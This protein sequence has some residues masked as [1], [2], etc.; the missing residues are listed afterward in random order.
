MRP[1]H[2]TSVPVPILESRTAAGRYRTAARG[3]EERN[4]RCP[5]GFTL[6]ELLVVMAVIA[7]LMAILLPALNLARQYA[8]ETVCQSNLRQMAMILKTYCDDHDGLFPDPTYIYHSRES[9]KSSR[10]RTPFTPDYGAQHP[11]TCRWHDAEI[12]PAGPLLRAHKELQGSLIPYVGNGKVLLCKTGA[13]ACRERGCCNQDP[14]RPRR[15][16]PPP[17]PGGGGRGGRWSAH[18]SLGTSDPN[19]PIPLIPQ[20]SYTM[21]GNLHRTFLTG[22]SSSGSL[23][24]IDVRTVRLSTLRRETQVTRSPAGV[25]AF[26]EE[27][28]WTINKESRWPA[29]Y[30]LSGPWGGTQDGTMN[31]PTDVTDRQTPT[32]RVTGAL[33]IGSLDIGPSYTTFDTPVERPSAS[34]MPETDV[35]DAFA[36]YHRPRGGDLNTGHSYV[37]MLDGHVR[38]VTVADQLRRSRRVENL[39]DSRLGPGGNLYLAWPLDTPPLAGW[40]NQ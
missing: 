23:D 21:N 38:K 3:T 19:G 16:Q 31:S 32:F 35:G 5:R 34:R 28:S 20:Y 29:P 24:G 9:F 1:E 30:N 10:P 18:R 36:T 39:P 40:E 7:L 27:N 14:N 13:R 33:T 12:G 6:T 26:G 11:W 17:P 22:S 2:V 15:P 25:F 37:S 8:A 4:G